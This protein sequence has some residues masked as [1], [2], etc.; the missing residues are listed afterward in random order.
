MTDARIGRSAK[1]LCP[2][3]RDVERLSEAWQE[4]DSDTVYLNCTH[5]RTPRLL[6]SCEGT[7]SVEDVIL[8]T[9]LA[10]KWFPFMQDDFNTIEILAEQK[11]REGWG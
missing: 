5:S 9:A 6:P 8:N 1:M 4:A 2:V 7:V 11:L 3:C 10:D